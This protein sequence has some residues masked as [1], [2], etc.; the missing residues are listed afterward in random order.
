MENLIDGIRHALKTE[1]RVGPLKGVWALL[2][3]DS[4][5]KKS[6]CEVLP[7]PVVLSMAGLGARLAVRLQ[8]A[9]NIAASDRPR[10]MTGEP[11]Q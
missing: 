2:V 9:K 6:R 4:E 3:V 5:Y 10:L 11:R 7:W 8:S 1:A